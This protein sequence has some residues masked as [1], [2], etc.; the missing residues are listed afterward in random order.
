MYGGGGFKTANLRLYKK[1]KGA[2]GEGTWM[3][4]EEKVYIEEGREFLQVRCGGG[5]KMYK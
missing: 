1:G 5:I 4:I 3:R 2:K